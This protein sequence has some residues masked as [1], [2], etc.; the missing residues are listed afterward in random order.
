MR[1]WRMTF[2]GQYPEHVDDFLG[3]TLEDAIVLAGKHFKKR[4][5]HIN[6]KTELVD[7][8]MLSPDVIREEEVNK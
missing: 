1:L 7:V 8:I 4:G 6:I 3:D 5:F 2:K